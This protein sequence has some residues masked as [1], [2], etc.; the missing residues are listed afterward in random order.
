MDAGVVAVAGFVAVS[1]IGSVAAMFGWAFR[2]EARERGIYRD[3]VLELDTKIKVRDETIDRLERQ[4]DGERA[5]RRY[6]EDHR[7][8]LLVACADGNPDVVAAGIR[9]E[10]SA[11]S[12]MSDVSEATPATS[13]ENS[14]DH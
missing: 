7:D 4:R 10:L 3:R 12:T 14:D 6:A 11:F 8:D 9:A 13:T 1:I 2:D 5:A